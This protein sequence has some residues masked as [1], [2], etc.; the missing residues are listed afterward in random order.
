VKKDGGCL[1]GRVILFPLPHVLFMLFS[2]GKMA[3]VF[4]VAIIIMLSYT[5]YKARALELIY[6]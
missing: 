2:R 3:A 4:Y 5:K 6:Y 1:F